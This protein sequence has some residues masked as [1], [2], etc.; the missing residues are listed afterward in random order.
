MKAPLRRIFHFNMTRA[1]H[2]TDGRTAAA[3]QGIFS[4][5]S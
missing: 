2:M 5:I 3:V 1:R 4:I